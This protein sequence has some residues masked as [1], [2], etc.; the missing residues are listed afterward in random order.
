VVAILGVAQLVM[1]V[2]RLM[3]GADFPSVLYFAPSIV[4][5]LAWPPLFNL[6]RVPLRPRA[7]PDAV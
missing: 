2:I 5:A 1:L 7:D 6:I 3:G 4:G